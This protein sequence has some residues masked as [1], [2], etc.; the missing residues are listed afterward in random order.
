MVDINVVCYE[1]AIERAYKRY[2][3]LDRAIMSKHKCAPFMLERLIS[4]GAASADDLPLN[5]RK[6]PF[7]TWEEH[8]P[9]A[10]FSRAEIDDIAYYKKMASTEGG[11]KSV[12][13]A[14]LSPSETGQGD[15][16]KD[17][18]EARSFEAKARPWN[19]PDRAQNGTDKAL[20]G[21]IAAIKERIFQARA[22]T[23]KEQ[24]R[25]LRQF[26]LQWHPDKQR[27]NQSLA[28]KVFQWLQELR[29]KT[30]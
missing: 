5:M 21:A 22:A 12:F 28:T 2:T 18:K 9:D 11:D 10:K 20:E 17:V 24:Q 6:N 8:F 14:F 26:F 4:L 3:A 13:R 1:W 29:E 27:E 19:F 7:Y 25:L 30:L 23:I 15:S 16:K